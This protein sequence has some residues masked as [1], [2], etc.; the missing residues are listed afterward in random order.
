MEE[1]IITIKAIRDKD[2]RDKKFTAA[3]QGIDLDEPVAPDITTLRGSQAQKTGFGIGA[4]VAHEVI[5]A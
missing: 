4:G 2:E 5:G 1:L 3:V